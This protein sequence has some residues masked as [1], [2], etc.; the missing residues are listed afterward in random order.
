MGADGQSDV[1]V[2]LRLVEM[3]KQNANR[4]EKNNKKDE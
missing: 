3:Q 1:L 4:G 2:T